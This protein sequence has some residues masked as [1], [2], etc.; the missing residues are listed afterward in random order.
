M[1]NVNTIGTRD[2]LRYNARYS[3]RGR[4]RDLFEPL[5]PLLSETEPPELHEH[6][7]PPEPLMPA[8]NTTIVKTVQDLLIPQSSISYRTNH[9]GE[10]IYAE[11]KAR[12]VK[13]NN[14]HYM[15]I[16]QNSSENGMCVS[17]KGAEWKIE[18]Q[19][20]AEEI[21]FG[22]NGLRLKSLTRYKSGRRLSKK[23]MIQG[24]QEYHAGGYVLKKLKA[25]LCARGY[26]E[27]NKQV[28]RDSPTCQKES[29]RLLLCIMSAQHWTLHS[30]D[31]KSA[32]LHGVPLDRE[33]YMT[34][35][36]EENTEK[37]WLLKKCTYG[38]SD[39]SRHW[40]LKVYI[41]I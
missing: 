15:N 7:D 5:E 38:L 37:I 22:T 9:D 26:E 30:M 40:Y 17:L 4:A 23:L 1:K 31:I 11:S 41:Y 2:Y 13:T 28:K 21:Y 3:S 33:L 34:P 20:T 25:R 29:L 35:P 36:K 12:K 27:V 39:V 18:D 32:Y 14:W 10:W 6:P 16:K 24:N 19:Q 8:L